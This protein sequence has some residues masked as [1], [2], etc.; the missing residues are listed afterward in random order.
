VLHDSEEGKEKWVIM[1]QY[2]IEMA[3]GVESGPKSSVGRVMAARD[4]FA[5]SVCRAHIFLVSGIL[6]VLPTGPCS[7]VSKICT[8]LGSSFIPGWRKTLA[9]H[10]GCGQVPV[11]HKDHQ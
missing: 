5:K 8:S 6:C 9:R 11:G 3:A 4:A 1:C 10:P 7:A 2:Y